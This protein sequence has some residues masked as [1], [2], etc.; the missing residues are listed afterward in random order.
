[1]LRRLWWFMPSLNRPQKTKAFNSLIDY[2]CVGLVYFKSIVP[3]EH[4]LEHH[5]NDMPWAEV[6]HKLVTTKNPRKKGDNYEI[7]D[8]T[9]YIPLRF[10]IKPF[11]SLTQSRDDNHEMPT[12]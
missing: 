6:I 12:M 3:T 11:G 1:M 5:V 9:C 8:G 4:Y 10:E 7:D 2:I